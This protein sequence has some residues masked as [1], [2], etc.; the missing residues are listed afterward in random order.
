MDFDITTFLK[1]T[2]VPIKLFLVTSLPLYKKISPD[3]VKLFNATN[4]GKECMRRNVY[5]F[6]KCFNHLLTRLP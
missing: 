1:W 2:N 6:S 4:K 3:V 5:S